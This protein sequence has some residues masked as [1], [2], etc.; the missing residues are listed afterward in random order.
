M[1]YTV[2]GVNQTSEDLTFGVRGVF[3][4]MPFVVPPNNYPHSNPDTSPG[5]IIRFENL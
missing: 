4:H 1:Y 3:R 5:Y 2:D